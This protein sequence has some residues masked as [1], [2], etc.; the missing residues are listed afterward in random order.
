[1]GDMPPEVLRARLAK[2]REQLLAQAAQNQESAGEGE[3]AT[4]SN[5]K[6]DAPMESSA[7]PRPVFSNDSNASN[8]I[9][10]NDSNDSSNSSNNTVSVLSSSSSSKSK[11]KI[12][13]SVSNFKV[14][15]LTDSIVFAGNVFEIKS[16]VLNSSEKISTGKIF[17]NFG[18]G[19][20]T[21]QV[22]NFQK[23]NHIYFYP[24]NYNLSL[25]YYSNAFN[26][27]PDFSSQMTIKVL[28]LVVSISKVGDAQDFFIELTNNSNNNLDISSWKLSANNKIF[29]FPKNTT[30]LANNKITISGKITN[31]VFGDQ[32]DLK[33]ISS[34]GEIVFVYNS[35]LLPKEI[36]PKNNT[37]KVVPKNT[38]VLSNNTDKIEDS[39]SE[40]KIQ[41]INNDLPASALLGSGEVIKSSNN[42]FFTI[43]FIFLLLG[44]IIL[45]YFIRKNRSIKEP[46]EGD[47]FEILDE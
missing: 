41:N 21:E 24:G 35:S 9:S 26:S 14:D 22:N 31:F 28:P 6:P 2:L 39:S 34:T 16:N 23:F 30:I 13:K 4:E 7:E 15:V 37:E 10:S 46:L 5:G 27:E 18:D 38:N 11:N 47:D 1:L 33:L 3:L 45:V 20:S 25:D 36:F 44:V 42:N 17:W 19:T 40:N 8:D 43:V 32:N 12:V 29:I